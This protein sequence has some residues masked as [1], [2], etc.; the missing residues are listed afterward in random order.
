M[1]KIIMQN[2]LIELRQACTAAG[3]MNVNGDMLLDVAGRVYN[4]EMINSSQHGFSHE[5]I[6]PTDKLDKQ[7]TDFPAT[8]KQKKFMLALKIPFA[9][10]ISK[11]EASALIK[12]KTGD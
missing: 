10:T 11:N 1:D 9:G 5:R 3:L 12:A 2:I 8:D 4:S 6:L 7:I